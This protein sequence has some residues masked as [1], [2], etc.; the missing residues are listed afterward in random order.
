MQIG[1]KP[2]QGS[3]GKFTTTQV[4]N[5]SSNPGLLAAADEAILYYT[6]I[7]RLRVEIIMLYGRDQLT[8]K[9]EVEE[10]NQVSR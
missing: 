10:E 4:R 7:S 5:L 1:I 8:G 3:H 9:L 6:T 2:K